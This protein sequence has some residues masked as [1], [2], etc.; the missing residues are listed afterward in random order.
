MVI[1]SDGTYNTSSSLCIGP[2]GQKLYLRAGSV[3]RVNS[4]CRVT[5]SIKTA[6]E[7]TT[8]TIVDAQLNRSKDVISGVG[9]NSSDGDLFSFTAIKK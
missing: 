4:A 1:K 5:G 3:L 9:K 8:N 7:S 2:D 6:G